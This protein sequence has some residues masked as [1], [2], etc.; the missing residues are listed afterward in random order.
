M[1]SKLRLINRSAT[2]CLLC[3]FFINGQ[4]VAV[5]GFKPL[6]EDQMLWRKTEA[7]ATID[8][9]Y[10][11][12]GFA[13]QLSSPQTTSTASVKQRLLAS[14]LPI[15]SHFV[16]HSSEKKRPL[17]LP[18][19]PFVS[20]K[21]Q[22]EQIIQVAQSLV[23]GSKPLVSG[24]SSNEKVNSYWLEWPKQDLKERLNK[25]LP[26][27]LSH[28]SDWQVDPA[29]VLSVIH[30]ES[31]FNVYARSNAP[32]YGLMQITPNMAG[33]DVSRLLTKTNKKI[34]EYLLFDPEFNLM[35]GIAYLHYLDRKYFHLVKNDVSRMLCV[36][37]AYNGGMG[38]VMKLFS[39]NGDS[40]ADVINSM[41]TDAV[42]QVLINSHPFA[43]TRN[44]VRKVYL[45]Y[46]FY[47]PLIQSNSV[48]K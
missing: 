22:P 1:L 36:I 33:R 6:T 14:I 43:E 21:W 37:A 29:L 30:Q 23:Y 39:S 24:D 17:Q 4:A 40:Y 16:E 35:V 19:L 44:Y 13:I 5:E 20:A 47:N 32:A 7:G 48:M 27:I 18:Y 9:D 46:S 8:V 12:Q 26:L 31:A 41:S 38:H 3:L 2:A 34:P 10:R 45:H 42:E 15:M 28:A 11:Q 25:W